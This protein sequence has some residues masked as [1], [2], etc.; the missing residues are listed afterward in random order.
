M[1]IDRADIRILSRLQ[2][3]AA[4]TVNELAEEVGLSANACWKRIRRLDQA[5]FI[6]RRVA[7]LD[8]KK[9]GLGVTV[10]VSVKTDQ[11]D[12]KWL[13]EF[14]AAIR[15]IPEVVEFYRMSGEVDY[16]LKVVCTD[17]EDYDR[18]YRKMIRSTK[19]RDVSAFFAMEQIKHTTELPLED[20]LS[21]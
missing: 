12:E 18:I 5:G 1:E 14:A 11:H 3:N 10:F 2:A 13:E 4:L 7:I 21:K 16:M 17:I 9:L 15:L 19:L 8:R 6:E 20:V